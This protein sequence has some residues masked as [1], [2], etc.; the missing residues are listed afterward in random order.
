MTTLFGINKNCEN[1]RK[2]YYKL[3]DELR[4]QKIAIEKKMESLK[5][6]HFSEYLKQLGNAALPLIPKAV[7]FEVY[8]PFGLSNEYSIYFYAKGKEN[9]EGK[10]LAGATFVSSENGYSLKD[11]SK[12]SGRF[13]TGT[14][15]EMNGM[16]YGTKP[17]TEEMT[18]EWFVKFAKKSYNK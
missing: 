13:A 7:D 5:Y 15:G 12:N 6:P 8:G 14:I 9:K 4:A 3:H 1:A 10:T 16:N 2:R 11:Y 18:L 17:I